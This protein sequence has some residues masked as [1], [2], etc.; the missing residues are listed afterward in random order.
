MTMIKLNSWQQYLS[1]YKRSIESPELFWEDIAESFE[2]K[3]KWDKVL[4]W[5]FEEPDVKWFN[6]GQLNITE[7][8]LDRHLEKIGDKVALHWVPNSKSDKGR[9]IT[10][11][12]LH[13]EVCK[14]SNVLVKNGV[15]KGDRVCLYMPMVPELVI[16]VLACARVGAI[17]SVVFAGFSA[18]SLSERINDCTCNLLIT[19]DGAFRGSKTIDLKSIVD[20]S[21]LTCNS[22]KKVIVLKRTKTEVPIIA[23]RDVWWH[24]E[25]INI[26]SNHQAETMNSEDT[27]FILYTSGSTGKPKGVVHS[28]GGYMIYAE[29]SFRNVFQYQANDIFWCTADIG[30]ITGHTYIIYGPLLAG[31]TSIM[32][33][34]IP[35]YPDAGRLWEIVDKYQVN[36]FYT[37]PTVIRTLQSKGLKYINPYKLNSLKVLGTVGEPINEEAWHWYNN[38]IGKGKCPIV[39]TWWQTETGGILISPLPGITNLKPCYATLPL[40]GIQLCLVDSEEMKF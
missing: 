14:F 6:G 32:F 3:K 28:T 1:N 16:A 27:L 21:L 29:Y 35:T 30:W 8:C 38:E 36:L 31:A 22:V 23:G 2:W 19:A 4:E 11:R 10:Y 7:N 15:K 26:S 5:N 37:A 9:K 34:G 20:E 25:M 12:D 18:Q 33:E 40:P 39:D 24:D 17:H 13:T